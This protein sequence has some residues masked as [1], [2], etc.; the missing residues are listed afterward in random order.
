MMTAVLIAILVASV[1][2]I[3]LVVAPLIMVMDMLTVAIDAIEKAQK[4]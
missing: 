3:G 2:L 4:E 1:A